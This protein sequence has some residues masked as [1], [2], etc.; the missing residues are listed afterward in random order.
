VHAPRTLINFAYSLVVLVGA[1]GSAPV[2][3]LADRWPIRRLALI[4]V[5]GTTVGLGLVSATTAMWQVLLLFGPL[6]A[7]ADIFIGNVT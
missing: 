2:G 3:W 5:V 4:G 6:I 7:T 1:V